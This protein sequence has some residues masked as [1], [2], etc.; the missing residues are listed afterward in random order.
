MKP[1]KGQNAPWF[2]ATGKVESLSE[3]VAATSTLTNKLRQAW[4]ANEQIDPWF[5][6]VTR[7]GYSLVPG[8]YRED[9][10]IDNESEYR[11]DFQ[12]KAVPYLDEVPVQPTSMWDWYLLMQHYGLPT[13]LLDWT[14]GSLI[15][16]YFAVAEDRTL[17]DAAVW[18]LDPYWLNDKVAHEGEWLK[19][20][21]ELDGYLPK[22]YGGSLRKKYPVALEPPWNSKRINAQRGMFTVH[23]SRHQAIETYARMKG[24]LVRLRVKRTAIPRIRRELYGAGIRESM[25]FPELG[26]VSS[27]LKRYW[28]EDVE[29]P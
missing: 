29:L 24:H 9:G 5:R 8:I 18:I 13:R 6:G 4:P 19:M 15:A 27:E 12:L 23:G 10:E 16:L 17:E 3:Y 21:D 26:R 1:D 7:I 2:S 25:L 14:E 11:L 28:T 20:V 22:P